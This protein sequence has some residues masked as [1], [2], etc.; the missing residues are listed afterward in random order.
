VVVSHRVYGAK[1]GP[2]AS[3]WLEKNGASVEKALMDWKGLPT[4]AALR[5]LPQSAK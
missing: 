5:A 1:A 4:L 2:A 3:E